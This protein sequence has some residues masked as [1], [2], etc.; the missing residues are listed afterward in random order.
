MSSVRDVV[1]APVSPQRVAESRCDLCRCFDLVLI[2]GD[3]TSIGFDR[4]FAGWDAHQGRVPLY[5]GYIAEHELAQGMQ[6]RRRHG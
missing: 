5:T 4:S 3:P 2:H 1:R 6:E